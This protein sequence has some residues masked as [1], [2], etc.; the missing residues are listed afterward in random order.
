LPARLREWQAAGG[1]LE[2]QKARL[3]PGD[4]LAIT[5]GTLALSQRGGLDAT[6]QLAAT[7][8]ER[9]LPTL[10]A[11]GGPTMSLER[12]APALNAIERAVPGLAQRIAPPQQQS[13]QAGLLGRHDALGK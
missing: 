3:A 12:A 6:L 4:A 5:R 8:I 7:G 13:L 10:G 11:G 1:K 9:F 2:I